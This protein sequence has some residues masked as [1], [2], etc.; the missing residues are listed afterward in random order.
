MN[1]DQWFKI[2]I[3]GCCLIICANGDHSGCEGNCTNTDCDETC[4]HGCAATF[5]Y[6]QFGQGKENVRLTASWANCPSDGSHDDGC[7]CGE[8]HFSWSP[9]EW[10]GQ[11]AGTRYDVWAEETDAG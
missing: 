1:L 6:D 8:G 7:A 11:I 9:C 10:C 2:S 3:C 4:D 5:G